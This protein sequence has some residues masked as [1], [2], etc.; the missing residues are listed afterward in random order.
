MKDITC[1]ITMKVNVTVYL[2]EPHLV[3]LI[4]LLVLEGRMPLNQRLQ[5]SIK[6]YLLPPEASFLCSVNIT[7]LQV[8]GKQAASESTA[9]AVIAE[10]KVTLTST[11]SRRNQEAVYYVS[12][13]ILSFA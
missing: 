5:T 12:H 6:N 9:K 7:V 1:L 4:A 3:A 8:T 11:E 13:L 10:C 2:Y